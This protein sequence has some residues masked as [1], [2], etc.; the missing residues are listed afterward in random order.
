MM[1][2]PNKPARPQKPVRLLTVRERIWKALRIMRVADV[3]TIALSVSASLRST[4]DYLR[5]LE[6]RGYVTCTVQPN[7]FTG[8][9]ATYRLILNCGP[10]APHLNLKPM[11]ARARSA[12][13]QPRCN[14]PAVI[15]AQIIDLLGKTGSQS[16]EQLRRGLGFRLFFTMAPF[17]HDMMRGGIIAI[18]GNDRF[19]LA[20]GQVA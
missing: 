20:K 7:R 19:V 10:V 16:A 3:P 12:Q 17:L 15:K 5:W 4:R 2:A 14:R 1:L 11:P 9:P 8:T 6:L 18:D 13:L